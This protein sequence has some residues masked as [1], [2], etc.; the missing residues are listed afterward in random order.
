MPAKNKAQQA[1][2]RRKAVGRAPVWLKTA[3]IAASQGSKP[4]RG[5][6]GAASPV[7]S[8]DPKT[9]LPRGEAA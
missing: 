8:I 4:V 5:T 9:G 3:A 2:S 7:I 1:R 6:F